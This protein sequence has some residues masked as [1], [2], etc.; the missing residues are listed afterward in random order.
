M[1]QQLVG[2][3]LSSGRQTNPDL[4]LGICGEHGGD[5]HP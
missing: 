1:R 5:R 2:C 4:E 3:F